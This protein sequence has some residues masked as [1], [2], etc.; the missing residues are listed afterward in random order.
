LGFILGIILVSV[1][2][3]DI[4]L[5]AMRTRSAEKQVKCLELE[6]NKEKCDLIFKNKQGGVK[7][8]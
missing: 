6:I 8:G 1:V 4:A 2:F 7:N 5:L 3:V